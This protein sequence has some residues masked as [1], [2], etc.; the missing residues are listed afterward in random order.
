M[1]HDGADL[2]RPEEEVLEALHHNRAVIGPAIDPVWA[3]PDESF[4]EERVRQQWIDLVRLPQWPNDV[5][6]VNVEV[7][8]SDQRRL[9]GCLLP[10]QD[11][12]VVIR[13]VDRADATQG[14][15]SPG[16]NRRVVVELPAELQVLRGKWWHIVPLDVTAQA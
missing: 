11:G 6:R 12:G 4:V 9:V 1:M 10:V 3:K 13:D 7:I 14:G 16:R 5:L 2:R 8:A 15:G